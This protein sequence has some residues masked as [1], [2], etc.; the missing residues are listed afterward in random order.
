VIEVLSLTKRYGDRQVL[1]GVSFTV[2]AGGATA[3]WGANG[4]GKS[5]TIRCLLGLTRCRGKV[6]VAGLDPLAAP[7]QVRRLV[8]YVPQEFAP[9]DMTVRQSLAFFGALKGVT[10]ARG[11]EVLELVGLAGP[12]EQ[13]QPVAALSG[14]MRQRLALAL[15][16]LADPP[17]LL[18]DEPTASLDSASR[19]HLFGL[20][21]ELRRG[22]KTILFASH[23]P[24]EVLELA[25]QVLVMEAGRVAASLTPAEFAT[26]LEVEGEQWRC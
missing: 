2:P 8:G 1:G 22:G 17:V 14:G 7:R 26:T 5:T 21:A 6:R 4:A 25:E 13:E 9:F 11:H 24:G 18:L 20:L 15:A 10:E 19:Q 16:L 3:L 12:A 23:R